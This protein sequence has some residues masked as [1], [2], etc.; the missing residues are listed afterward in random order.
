MQTPR[1]WVAV[2]FSMQ[3]A[4]GRIAAWVDPATG[5]IEDPLSGLRLISDKAT[6]SSGEQLPYAM[7]SSTAVRCSMTSSGTHCVSASTDG[8]SAVVRSFSVPQPIATAQQLR[9]KAA[10]D[11]HA[12]ADAAEA[13]SSTA[14]HDST[15]YAQATW[16]RIVHG[17]TAGA[18]GGAGSA[19][20][21]GVLAA[22]PRRD[23]QRSASA[24]ATLLDPRHCV[25]MLLTPRRSVQRSNIP[26]FLLAATL[27]LLW[28]VLLLAVGCYC[29]AAVVHM[30]R[31]AARTCMRRQSR[32]T[33]APDTPDLKGRVV[34][35]RSGRQS[36]G[37][38]KERHAAEPLLLDSDSD[39]SGASTPTV[40][41]AYLKQ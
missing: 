9:S 7:R 11:I 25:F 34:G 26:A 27:S 36:G 31:A 4:S 37:G 6:L 20:M 29:A 21:L 40:S 41:S 18:R 32:R 13:D 35:R 16:Q 1:R 2:G 10:L 19:P 33:E 17:S 5:G 8:R 14:A 39:S 12:E 28:T 22:M 24:S 3:H 15:G 38:C 30:L 23:M